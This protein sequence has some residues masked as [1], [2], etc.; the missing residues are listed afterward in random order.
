MITGTWLDGDNLRQPCL[1]KI[2]FS[3]FNVLLVNISR[4]L[5]PKF[6]PSQTDMYCPSTVLFAIFSK[7]PFLLGGMIL[8]IVLHVVRL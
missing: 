4:V 5:G 7:L 6:K 1:E 3:L 2:L 8:D